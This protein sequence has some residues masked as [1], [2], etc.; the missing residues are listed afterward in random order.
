MVVS[1]LHLYSL[2]GILFDK[3]ESFMTLGPSKAQ[4]WFGLG[5]MNVSST[6]KNISLTYKN[7]V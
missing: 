1:V 4:Q 3:I 5:Y 6:D 7:M 2:K